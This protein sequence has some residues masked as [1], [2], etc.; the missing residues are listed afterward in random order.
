M[1][2]Q[3]VTIGENWV[4][5]AFFLQFPMTLWLFPNKMLFKKKR[6]PGFCSKS[7]NHVPSKDTS[8]W[9]RQEIILEL[10][11]HRDGLQST[12]CPLINIYWVS[13]GSQALC[14][15]LS[16]TKWM[17]YDPFLCTPNLMLIVQPLNH[18]QLCDPLDGSTLGLSVTIS[19]GLPKFMSIESVMLSNHS[20]LIKMANMIRALD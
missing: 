10:S 6:Y 18:V 9:K 15:K 3:D 5:S 2:I 14:W 11:L 19:W 12:A 8:L 13:A 17:I 1:V 4:K 7:P 16:D 20:M